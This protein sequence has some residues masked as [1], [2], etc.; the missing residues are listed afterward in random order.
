MITRTAKIARLPRAV[1]EELNGRLLEREPGNHL[2]NWLNEKP[3]ALAKHFGRRSISEQNLSVWRQGG[4]A[5]WR[6]YQEAKEVRRPT[7]RRARQSD[8]VPIYRYKI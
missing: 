2:V 6:R 1:R 7:L 8:N 4:F 5:D 3:E